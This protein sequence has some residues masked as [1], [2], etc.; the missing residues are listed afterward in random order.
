[1]PKKQTTNKQTTHKQSETITFLSKIILALA[2]ILGASLIAF[3]IYCAKK[4]SISHLEQRELEAFE[5]LAYAYIDSD[6]LT[7]GSQNTTQKITNIG[8]SDDDDLYFDFTIFYYDDNH[9][10]VAKKDGKAFLQ[11]DHEYRKPVTSDNNKHCGF[12]FSYGEKETI[13]N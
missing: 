9:N 6:D 10:A 5:S 3:A 2:I 12:A 8:L 13:N 4:P 11:C 7:D 1:M